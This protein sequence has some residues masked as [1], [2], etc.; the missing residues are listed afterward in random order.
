M[1]RGKRGRGSR[2]QFFLGRPFSAT[3]DY[4]ERGIVETA[5]RDRE[6][7]RRLRVGLG[8]GVVAV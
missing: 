1:S 3:L 8:S 6:R 2:L 4:I 5:A 7:I